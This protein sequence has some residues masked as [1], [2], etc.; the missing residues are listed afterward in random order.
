M[1][2]D[3]TKRA[4]RNDK[5]R[6][7]AVL[8]ISFCLAEGTE[9]ERLTNV[10]SARGWRLYFLST[11]NYSL[12]TLA[13]RAGL[14]IDDAERGRFVDIPN[15][16][17]G[18]GIYEKLNQFADGQKLTDRLKIRCRKFCGAVGRAFACKLVQD[19]ANDADRLKQFLTSRRQ[20]YLRAI[21]AKVQAEQLKPLNRAS[22][23]FATVY[24]AGSLAIKYRIFLWGSG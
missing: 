2:L 10:G 19:R 18:H 7:Q 15:P 20:A 21:N 11:S 9:K 12:A 3:D 23:R 5:D 1:L 6:G 4:G 14:E 16:N 8:D 24:A 22:G 17:S 13:H